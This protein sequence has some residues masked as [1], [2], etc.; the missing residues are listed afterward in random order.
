MAGYVNWSKLYVVYGYSMDTPRYKNLK[1]DLRDVIGAETSGEA[2][3]IRAGDVTYPDSGEQYIVV[4]VPVRLDSVV[5]GDEVGNMMEAEGATEGELV[6][7]D[8]L[9]GRKGFVEF[10]PTGLV[11]AVD[12]AREVWDEE[13]DLAIRDALNEYVESVSYSDSEAPE[14]ADSPSVFL[15]LNTRVD[16]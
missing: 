13:L 10:D 16:R 1:G 3:V 12:A 5:D 4:G 2:V 9:S 14:L 7:L 11:Q 15:T 6:E 8:M